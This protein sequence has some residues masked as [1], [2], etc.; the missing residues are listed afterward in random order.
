M[1]IIVALVVLGSVLGQAAAQPASP[2]STAALG[3]KLTPGANSFM[4]S[5]ARAAIAAKGFGDISRLVNDEHGI[6]RGTATRNGE[7]V[8]V[9][10]DY[11]GQV[12][13]R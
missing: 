12:D 2:D 7:T 10:V 9:S 13:A 5:Q 8:H 3:P 6:W 4:E 11:K 1:R